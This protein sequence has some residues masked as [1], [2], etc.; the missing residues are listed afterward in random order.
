[1]KRAI[2]YSLTTAFVL[3]LLVAG[4][5]GVQTQESNYLSALETFNNSLETY[6][7]HFSVADRDTQA[8][9]NKDVEPFIQTASVAL[10]AWGKAINDPT[11]KQGYSDLYR[12]MRRV[13]LA[14]GIVEVQQ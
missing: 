9:W 7:F 10:D 5:V 4:C 14:A 2:K 6:L 12:E 13:I 11:A 8:K 3:A 1:M